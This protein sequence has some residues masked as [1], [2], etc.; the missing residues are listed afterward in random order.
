MMCLNGSCMSD[1]VH[2]MTRKR[3]KESV[4]VTTDV[5]ICWDLNKIVQ[6]CVIKVCNCF[7]DIII[8]A[9]EIITTLLISFFF[10]YTQ[11]YSCTHAGKN[12]I[13]RSLAK[14]AS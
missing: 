5:N 6:P 1:P 10:I 4:C 13:R 8:K 2:E 3:N 11:H 14:N 9:L 7:A 12:G